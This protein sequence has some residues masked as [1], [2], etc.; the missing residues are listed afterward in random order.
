CREATS[1]SPPPRIG[2]RQSRFRFSS[3]TTPSGV[4]ACPVGPQKLASSKPRA[5]S[6]LR[7]LSYRLRLKSDVSRISFRLSILHPEKTRAKLRMLVPPNSPRRWRGRDR[8]LKYHVEFRGVRQC[9][10]EHVREHFTQFGR[11][12]DNPAFSAFGSVHPKI[13]VA[14]HVAP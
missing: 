8:A 13:V 14:Q 3:P 6:E 11:A 9:D 5:A 4:A 7:E 10:P 2:G 1:P 12:R